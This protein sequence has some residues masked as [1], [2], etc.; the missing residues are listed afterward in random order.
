M[1]VTAGERDVCCLL[2]GPKAVCA[3]IL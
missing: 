3:D 1:T 2:H